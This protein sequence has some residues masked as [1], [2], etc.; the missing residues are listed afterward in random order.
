[1]FGK[2]VMLPGRGLGDNGEREEEPEV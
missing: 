1:L 2:V